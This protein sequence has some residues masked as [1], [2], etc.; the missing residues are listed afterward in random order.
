MHFKRHIK[1]HLWWQIIVLVL[2]IVFAFWLSDKAQNETVIQDWVN[3]FGYI[4]I[5]VVS[6]ISGFNFAV[7]V[8]AITFLPLFL[9]SSL[10]FPIT[11]LVI[12]VGMT[13]ADFIA[14]W[15]AR[16]GEEFIENDTVRRLE[17]FRDKW[18][19]LPLVGLGL[20]AAFIPFPNEIL[21]VP[22]S[23]M[24]YRIRYLL[25]PLLIGNLVFNIITGNI[26]LRLFEF[27]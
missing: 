14:Y 3:R 7:P 22:L 15:I 27:F 24:K 25:G 17:R 12:T 10:S 20:Y 8:P 21:V 6:V 19:W 23:L 11:L 13:L 26:V 18:F 2:V 1:K 5:F 16:T 4:G 9:A